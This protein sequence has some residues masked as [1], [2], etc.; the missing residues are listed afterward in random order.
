MCIGWWCAC[1]QDVNKDKCMTYPF[2][3]QPFMSAQS[4]YYNNCDV[5]R[6]EKDTFMMFANYVTLR[7]LKKEQSSPKKNAKH[8]FFSS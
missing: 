2:N 4:K 3:S 8:D 5:M 6:Y 1:A 7:E